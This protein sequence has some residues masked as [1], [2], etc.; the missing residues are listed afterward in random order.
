MSFRFPLIFSYFKVTVFQ[1]SQM[2]MNDPCNYLR[3]VRFLLFILHKSIL[4]IQVL[5]TV[6]SQHKLC[7]IWSICIV[8]CIYWSIAY[9]NKLLIILNT[10]TRSRVVHIL[11]ISDNNSVII[12]AEW[13]YW[14]FETKSRFKKSQQEVR[15]PQVPKYQ[16]RL[17]KPKMV[18]G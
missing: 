6:S 9:L 16:Q 12:V 4:K 17:F 15:Y 2:F 3:S 1:V 10:F 14:N 5:V 7:Q 11:I 8:L 13:L 18:E